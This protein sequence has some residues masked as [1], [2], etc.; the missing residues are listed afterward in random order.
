MPNPG[1]VSNLEHRPNQGVS[2]GGS[3]IVATARYEV[4]GLT[5]AYC[6]VE[7]LDHVRELPGVA[8]V[9]VDLVRGGRS[10]VVVTADPGTP[11]EGVRRAIQ[12][13]GFELLAESA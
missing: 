5:C 9:S 3:K 2:A 7:I 10:L 1:G 11:G 6:I 13:G 12:G 8:K 4:G